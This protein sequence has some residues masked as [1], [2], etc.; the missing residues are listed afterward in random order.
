MGIR[1]LDMM[2]IGLGEVFFY[3]TL[4]SIEILSTYF[5]IPWCHP[6][7][8]KS[9]TAWRVPRYGVFSDPY[10]PIFEHIPYLELFSPNTGKD[11]P[12]K[13]S[14]F[15]TFQKWKSIKILQCKRMKQLLIITYT[16]CFYT[17]YPAWFMHRKKSSYRAVKNSHRKCSKN[18][19][20]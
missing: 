9:N 17:F 7:L 2:V 20:L 16:A 12:E 15:D 6:M 5:L 19:F 4:E 11:G 3:C 13:T 18:K 10:F 14:Y 8:H 1:F